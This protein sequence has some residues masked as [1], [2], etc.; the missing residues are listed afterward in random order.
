M[1]TESFYE[2]LSVREALRRFAEHHYAIKNRHISEY[3]YELLIQ[4]ADALDSLSG[5]VLHAA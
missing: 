2:G 4:V 3:E 1:P 5:Q